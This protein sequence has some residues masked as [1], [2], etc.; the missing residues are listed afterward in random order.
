MDIVESA[1]AL[2]M[3]GIVVIGMIRALLVNDPAQ[4][5]VAADRT[6]ERLVGSAADRIVDEVR[7]LPLE[8]FTDRLPP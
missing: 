3:I 4:V 1:T 6:T 2:V 8:A 7:G 5:Q